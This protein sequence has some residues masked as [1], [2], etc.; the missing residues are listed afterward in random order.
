MSNPSLPNNSGTSCFDAM[1]FGKY[2]GRELRHIP[3]GYLLWC[4]DSLM[5]EPALEAAIKT[6]LFERSTR[7]LVRLLG[8]SPGAADR[9]KDNIA[10][11]IRM[12]ERAGYTC[13]ELK[14]L[15]P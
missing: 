12:A 2:K 13:N 6:E 4:R 9:F 7:E 15:L 5:L 11:L 1:P 14:E 8:E 10:D 3:Q